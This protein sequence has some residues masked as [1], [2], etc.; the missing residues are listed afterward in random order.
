MFSLLYHHFAIAYCFCSPGINVYTPVTAIL[1][2]I[3][4]LLVGALKD[5]YE[6]YLRHKTDKKTNEK[7][8]TAIRNG[9]LETVEAQNLHVGDF[10]LIKEFLFA[11]C[12][13]LVSF[14]VVMKSLR[15]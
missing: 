3:F 6:D 15:T 10:V 13:S 12:T 11:S 9:N 1:P 7:P 8:V 2:L 14:L 5:G 4:I